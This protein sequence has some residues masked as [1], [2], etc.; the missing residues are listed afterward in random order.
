M[1]KRYYII[2]L[3]AILSSACAELMDDSIPSVGN[4]L[5]VAASIEDVETKT[6]LDGVDMYWAEGDAIN[7]AID[8]DFT[9]KVVTLSTFTMASGA[10]EKTA[11]FKS[12]TADPGTTYC[13][14][15]PATSY[16]KAGEKYIF[17]DFPIEQEYVQNGIKDGYIPMFAPLTNDPSK[18][19]FLY[20]SGVVRLNL[21]DTNAA[22]PAKIT[23]IEVTTDTPASGVMVASNLN[24]FPFARLNTNKQ[25]TITY[26]V[27]DVQL[28]SDS[29]A[30]TSFHICL[31]NSKSNGIN[32][33]LPD[34]VYASIKYTIY[35]SDGRIFTKEKNN[36]II[37]GGKI[38]NMSAI[39][40]EG[41][42]TYKVGDYYPNPSVDLSNPAEVAKVKGIVYAVTEDGKHG[43]AF[44]INEI[45]GMKWS[46]SGTV[47]N[48]D[49]QE[50]GTVNAET[51]KTLEAEDASSI[52]YPAFTEV[53]KF[54][55]G[56]YIPALNELLAI[57]ALR[58][59]STANI[60][61]MDAKLTAVGGVGFSQVLYYSS[62]E[63]E[64]GRNKAWSV[65]FKRASTA[66]DLTASALKVAADGYKFRPVIKF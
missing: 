61:A 50:D 65:N 2:A 33:C 13:A 60:K 25:Y 5:E 44:S 64:A 6:H 27:P 17:Y 66:V 31:A 40:F 12:E 46:L 58:G 63:Y 30:P 1:R 14:A 8:P 42:Y 38:Y 36:Q 48:T 4:G 21:Y 55:E 32:L 3:T 41:A 47:D 54:G 45:T 16:V 19:K 49:D 39:P 59:D 24:R 57:H 11:V 7:V 51:I 52:Q 9:N 22:E 53:A 35:A 43:K 10:N 26:D 15:Y 62:T 28:S 23:K 20:G 18:L 29:S 34:G 56:W 37:E